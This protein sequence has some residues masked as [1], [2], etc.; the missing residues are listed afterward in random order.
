M[1][2]K[3]LPAGPFL[4]TIRRLWSFLAAA[5]V[6]I[7]F[8]VRVLDQADAGLLAGSFGMLLLGLYMA[9]RAFV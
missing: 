8:G 6:G 2:G 9:G 7:W 5:G 4:A 1:S 3:A